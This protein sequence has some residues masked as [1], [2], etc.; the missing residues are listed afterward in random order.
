MFLTLTSTQVHF[1]YRKKRWNY[2]FDEIIELGLIRKKK[3]Y[4]LLNATF[5]AVTAIAYYCM[6]FTKMTDLYYIIPALLAYT[7][8]IILR[9][10]NPAEFDY[11]V[12]VR[13]CY[14]KEII[15]KIK[16]KDKNNM[17]KQIDEFFNHQFERMTMQT[18]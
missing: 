10:H 18:A 3:N 6:I 9:L 11:Y 2:A 8:L 13:D 12:F 7:V 5:I 16:N 1:C 4:F 15:V 14:E 17:G